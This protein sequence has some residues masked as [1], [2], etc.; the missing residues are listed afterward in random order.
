MVHDMYLAQVKAPAQSARDW[1]FYR[2]LRRI[3]GEKAFPPLAESKCKFV[4]PS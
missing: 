3:P 2:I 4:K 1:D